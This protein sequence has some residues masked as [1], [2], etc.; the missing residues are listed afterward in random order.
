MIERLSRPDAASL[1]AAP[2]ARADVT[3]LREEAAAIRQ[4]LDDLAADAVVGNIT[5]SQLHAASARATARLNAIDAELADT[6]REDVLAPLVTADDVAAA[7][8]ALDLSR[9]R[10]VLAALWDVVLHPTGRGSRGFGPATIEL[11]PA[12]KSE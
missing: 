5:R 3:A 4:R 8:D 10:A 11:R 6:G 12:G 9:K 1:M 7:W 2:K